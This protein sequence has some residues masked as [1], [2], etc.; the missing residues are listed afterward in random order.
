MTLWILDTDHVSLF[1]RNHPMVREYV[2]R[3]PPLEIFVTI[4]TVEEQLR[5][6]LN[7]VRR[8]T[9]AENLEAAYT[10]LQNTVEFFNSV[11]VLRFDQCASSQYTE[12]VR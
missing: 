4:V 8:A 9:S 5:G 1:Q 12:F 6:R 2:T 10:A 11:Q 3:I 7:Q